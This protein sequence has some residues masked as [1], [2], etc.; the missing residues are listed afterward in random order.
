MTEIATIHTSITPEVALSTVV[1]GIGAL[2]SASGTRPADS[3]AMKRG[4]ASPVA[5]QICGDAERD[6]KAEP[7]ETAERTC[8]LGHGNGR[9]R[10]GGDVGALR[11]RGDDRSA[12]DL[13]R[14]SGGG[15]RKA[16]GG[17]RGGAVVAFGTAAC[18]GRRRTRSGAPRRSPSR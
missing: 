15:R 13:Q 1:P 11:Q 4:S 2:T 7:G 18:G 8:S 9:G 10:V 16:D 5:D 6:R 14:G 12:P 3:Q 17:D